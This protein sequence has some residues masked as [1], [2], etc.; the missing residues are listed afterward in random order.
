MSSYY[1]VQILHLHCLTP[2]FNTSVIF[3]PSFPFIHHPPP[4]PLP[5]TRSA[6]EIQSAKPKS[7]SLGGLHL[8]SLSSSLVHIQP[9]PHPNASILPTALLLSSFSS[10]FL[11]ISEFPSAHSIS[12]P[13]PHTHTHTLPLPSDSFL[14]PSCSLVLPSYLLQGS[15]LPVLSFTHCIKLTVLP[16]SS[17][18]ES[19]L[20]TIPNIL[21]SL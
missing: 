2:V 14:Y 20:Q 4:P 9:F 5:L 6:L 1:T 19:S 17:L 18:R 7:R 21:I 12:I 8:P 10:L 3:S 13:P 16:L 11:P 15:L